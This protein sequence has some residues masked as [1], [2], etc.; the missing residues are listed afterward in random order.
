MVHSQTQTCIPLSTGS[1]FLAFRVRRLMS[2]VILAL[3]SQKVV[4]DWSEAKTGFRLLPSGF[5]L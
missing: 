4:S 3:K 5:Y 2:P 1:D